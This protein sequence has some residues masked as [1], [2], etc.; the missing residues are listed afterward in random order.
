MLYR[1]YAIGPFLLGTISLGLSVAGSLWCRT[2]EVEIVN[3][4]PN[5]NGIIPKFE[6]GIFLYRDTEFIV[7][8]DN[9]G[10]V[11]ERFD[12]CKPYDGDAWNDTEWKVA[13][14]TQLASWFI[15]FI[16]VTNLFFAACCQCTVWYYRGIGAYFWLLVTV[17]DGM[18]FWAM[19]SNLCNG[20]N[21]LLGEEFDT[22]SYPPQSCTFGITAWFVVGSLIGYFFTGILCFILGRTETATSTKNTKEIEA[23]ASEQK[24][25]AFGIFLCW[26][27]KDKDDENDDVAVIGEEEKQNSTHAKDE[28]G[29]LDLT[30]EDDEAVVGLVAS[31]DEAEEFA[32]TA[33]GSTSAGQITD[34]ENSKA[35]DNVTSEED[36]APLDESVEID[37]GVGGSIMVEAR[38][39]ST[40]PYDHL[41]ISGKFDK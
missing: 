3:S 30:R 29:T 19:Q 41:L 36:S 4:I 18:I 8:E 15:A 23:V 31:D 25:S 34:E 17:L 22:L 10:L 5:S 2:F 16:L 37:V 14:L 33:A 20:N 13:A 39:G 11:I 26:K 7:N 32:S 9:Q 1:C 21:P 24:T 27:T 35:S 6:T 28:I 38:T 40:T 12:T